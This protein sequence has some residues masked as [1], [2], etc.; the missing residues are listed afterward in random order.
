MNPSL[1][2]LRALITLAD[3]GRFTQSAERLGVSQS[4]LSASIRGL[5][6][7]L[8][9]RLFDRHTRMVRLTQ[10][11]AEIVPQVRRLLADLEQVVGASRKLADLE[12]GHLSLAAPT[13]QAALWLP[14]LIEDFA[15]DYPKVRVT[16]HDAPEQEILRLVRSGVADIGISTAAG[17]TGDL[18][19]RPFYRDNYIAALHPGHPL[20]SRGEITWR[21][22]EKVPV[23]APLAG[24]PVRAALDQVLAR[25]GITLNY[26]Y[27]VSLPWTMMGLVRSDLGVAVATDAMRELAGW[28]KLQVRP[29]VRPVIR[30]ELV[31]VTLKDRSLPPGAQRFFDR[32]LQKK[33]L[34]G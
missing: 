30:R 21:D 23:I 18:R 22:L 5:E 9:V 4:S 27:E 8:A 20:A 32:L 19:I 31:L 12:R 2:Q 7:C 25:E 1:R 24:N 11:G 10:A 15:R 33:K 29:I 6:R 16:L 13:V 34:R 28:M 3:V 26:A 17:V 14:P